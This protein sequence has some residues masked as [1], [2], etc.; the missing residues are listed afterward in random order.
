MSC[1]TSVSRGILGLVLG[2][3]LAVSLVAFAGSASAQVSFTPGSSAA[4]TSQ[5]LMNYWTPARM[6]AAQPMPIP[7][8]LIDPTKP[9]TRQA[10]PVPAA[11]RTLVPAYPPGQIPAVEQRIELPEGTPYFGQTSAAPMDFGVAPTEPLNGP[12]GPFQR[13]TM[14]GN[15]LVWPRSIHGKLFF[16]LNGGD[17]ACSAT[18]IGRSTI[19]TAGHCVSD[20]SGTFATS[21]LFCPSYYQGGAYPTRGCWGWAFVV[22]SAGWHFSGSPDYDYACIVTP[23][24]G[25]VVA[26]KIG[27]VTGTA[28]R[29]VNFTDVPEMIFGYP[30]G[31]PFPGNIIQMVATTDWYS[32][33]ADAGGQVSKIVGNDLTGGSSGG[34]WFLGWRA[35]GAEVA[36]TDGS[37]STD[38]T[39][40]GPYI[41]GVNSHKRCK[42]TCNEPPALNNGKYWQE[43]SSPPFR[44]TAAGD[45][46]E[47]IFAAC[48]AHANNNP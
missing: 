23:V 4:A 28:G 22:T 16:T 19:A 13:W 7:G 47:D 6:A 15:Y 3:V 32:W 39:T 12:Y 33:D 30:A 36:D 48:L 21:L 43:M 31:P 11:P 38:P 27:N 35:P 18:V 2:L 29:A 41:N 9:V 40:A 8:R 20:G 26:N 17:F 25:T 44:G 46:S 45:E 1:R 34:G 10:Q 37:W 24:T 42:V 14:E 5:A